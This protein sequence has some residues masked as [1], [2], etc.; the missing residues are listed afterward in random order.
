MVLFTALSRFMN[1][2]DTSS[3]VRESITRT[4]PGLL[5]EP[6][7]DD[8]EP[9]LLD[10]SFDF[11]TFFRRHFKESIFKSSKKSAPKF[12]RLIDHFQLDP[13]SFMIPGEHLA[14]L[15]A[16]ADKNSQD[17]MQAQREYLGYFQTGHSTRDIP[18]QL[19][20]ELV[21]KQLERAE[22]QIRFHL[23]TGLRTSD[24]MFT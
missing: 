2:L 22:Q 19:V 7:D 8:P 16:L 9:G 24:L 20:N 6:T 3:E 18:D 14:P 5:S 11:D 12:I 1:V 17:F 13:E 4:T 15:T 21:A 23:D 10:P